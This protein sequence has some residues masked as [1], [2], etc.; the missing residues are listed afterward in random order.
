VTR[1]G[2][3]TG[4]CLTIHGHFYQ[5][6][7]EN[8]WLEA[9]E[10][11]DG[12]APFHDWNE[13]IAAECYGP[14][15]T[16]RRVDGEN[17][18]LTIVNNFEKIS[19]NVGPTLFAWL[20]RH[21]PE[22]SARIVEADRRS[23]TARGGHGNA[24]A[25]AY[26]HLIMPLATRRDQRTQVRWGIADFRRRF[27]RD[28]EGMWLPETAVDAQTLDVLAECGIGFTILAPAQ[29]RRVRPVGTDRW[30]EVGG[31]R[32]DPSV[33]Y[34]Y[35]TP[36]GRHLALFFYDGPISR[37]IA[38]EGALAHGD[39]LAARLLAGVSP[40]RP[41]PQLVHAATDGESYGH[42]SRFGDMAL[43]A[44][45]ERIEREGALTITNYGAYLAA[46]PP[47]HEVEIVERTA[48]SCA[49]GV[50][51]WRADCGC[52]A[53]RDGGQQ[54]WRAPLRE[55][56]D[57]L[58]DALDPLFEARLG[59]LVRDPWAARDDYIEV[60]L[61]RSAA[62]RDAFFARHQHGPLAESA[63]VEALELLECQRHRLLMYASDAWFFDEV[64]GLETVQGMR[65][66]ARAMQLARA[67]GPDGLEAEFVRRLEAAPSNVAAIGT[68]A[69]VYRR[70]VRPAVVDVPRVAAHYAISG[71]LREYGD[72][73]RI[74]AFAVRRLDAQ[75]EAAA[76]TA[77]TVG[78]ARVRSEITTRSE[79]VAFAALHFGG[80]DFHC[81]VGAA[82]DPGRYAAV[83]ADLLGRYAG[84]GLSEVVRGIDQHFAGRTYALRDLFVEE[85][86]RIL[87]D[88]LQG[89]LAGCA[90]A[91]RTIWEANRRLIITLRETGTPIPEPLLGVARHVLQEEATRLAEELVATG[92]IPAGARELIAEARTLGVQLDRS[93]AADAVRRAIERAMETLVALGAGPDGGAER[94]G[95]LR[96]LLAAAHGIGLDLDLWRTQN[97]FFDLWQARPERRALLRPL[98]EPL[99]FCLD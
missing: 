9:V 86:R 60:V 39:T 6:P 61:D 17:R 50:E 47:A 32:I 10:P 38:F 2:A 8:P 45:L 91:Y 43:A 83:K 57:W 7:R 46:H 11:E 82:T 98:V 72:E 26:N 62:A 20:E 23:R 54:R 30:T 42:H 58:R 41:G 48:W 75:R 1:A 77:L 21:H 88:L 55:A 3:A 44:A 80:E 25:Q 13:R 79:D 73:S 49:H 68:G 51:R 12:A 16:A 66:A 94:V 64:S 97:L 92:A 87:A 24:L 76:G 96:A 84:A 37:A 15:T 67:L 56:M 28:P 29:A 27:G 65:H 36:G 69:E 63:V 93:A 99:G 35:R 52:R 71:L 90:D 95:A 4:R 74:Y 89:A 70:L 33:P 85:R 31:E 34:L 59:A 19:F 40:E 78:R 14:N 81:G 53:G 22:T 5:P 18:I